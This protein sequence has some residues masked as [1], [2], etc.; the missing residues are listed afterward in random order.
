MNGKMRPAN[1]EEER[2]LAGGMKLACALDAVRLASEKRARLS[3]FDES[4]AIPER[5]RNDRSA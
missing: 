2:L 5:A 4:A 1:H 3:R